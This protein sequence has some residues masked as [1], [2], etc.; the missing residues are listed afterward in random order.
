MH[1]KS[2]F[3]NNWS[4]VFLDKTDCYCHVV[5]V[6]QAIFLLPLTVSNAIARIDSVYFTNAN[7]SLEHIEVMQHGTSIH[8]LRLFYW[9]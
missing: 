1:S 8:S 7:V 4:I 5:V 6:P 3:F 9:M 2:L